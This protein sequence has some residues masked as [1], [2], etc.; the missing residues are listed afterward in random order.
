MKKLFIVLFAFI[1]LQTYSQSKT[2]YLEKNRFDLTLS[3]FEF[4]QENFKIIGFGAYH[5]SSKT[6]LTENILLKSLTKDGTIKYYLPETDFSIGHFFNQYLKTGDTLLLKDLVYNYG[7]RVPQEKSIETY[8]K[9]KEIKKLN[10]SLTKKNKLTVVGIDLL[11]TYKYT[12]KHLLEVLDYKESQEK[13]LQEIV[14]MVQLDTTDFSPH[15]RSYSKNILQS[16][17]VAYENNPTRFKTIIKDDFVFEH[18][19]KNLKNTFKNF[20]NS[21]KRESIIY[22]NYVHLSTIYHFDQKPQFL[23]FGFFH[24]EKQREGKNPS[25]FTRLIENNVYKRENIISVIG[26]LTDSRVLWD[27][28]YDDNKKYKTFT[29][30]G[31]FGIGD[32]EKEYF[33]GIDNLK[34]TKISDITLFRLNGENTTYSDGIPDLMEIVMEDDKSNREQVKGKSTTEFLDYAVLISNSKASIPIEAMK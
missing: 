4:P 16:F 12:S 7:A 18:I 14:N 24:I 10:D 6:E 26:Y 8:E 30:E 2:E 11:V 25:F 28:V 21:S 1:T 5:G 22:D 23:R 34:K 9:W 13:S 27:I 31:G 20:D 19:V 15:Y 3:E 33:L 17:I 29:T 32:Y